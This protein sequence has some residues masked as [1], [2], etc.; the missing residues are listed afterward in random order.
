MELLQKYIPR[1]TSIIILLL[2]NIST[3][4]GKQT[5]HLTNID[6]TTNSN[7]ELV[8]QSLSVFYGSNM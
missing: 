7:V 5:I 8:I 3:L 6:T 2:I 4:S 1:I